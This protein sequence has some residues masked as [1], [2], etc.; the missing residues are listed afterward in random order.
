[1]GVRSDVR[2]E[3]NV[4]LL[5][6]HHLGSRPDVGEGMAI[7]V[8]RDGRRLLYIAH[9]YAPVAMS[10]LDVTDPSDPTFLWELPCSHDDVR[11]NSSP[12]TATRSCWHSR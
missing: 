11:G 3:H 7:K 12:S 9:A 1:M 2:I 4:R 10:V 5:A 8:T 6:R